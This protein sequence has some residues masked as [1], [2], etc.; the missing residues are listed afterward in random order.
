MPKIFEV[1]P[2]QPIVGSS[3]ACDPTLCPAERFGAPVSLATATQMLIVDSYRD[4]E[5]APRTDIWVTFG[6]PDEH[7]EY[8]DSVETEPV[9]VDRDDVLVGIAQRLVE[10]PNGSGMQ[11]V[12]AALCARVA[13]CAGPVDGSCGALGA[14][15]V[16]EVL[17]EANGLV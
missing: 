16:R 5:G 1:S 8:P 15:A 9:N 13:E 6:E 3:D 7:G 11:G 4:S 2:D 12:R 14:S 17:S 10:A